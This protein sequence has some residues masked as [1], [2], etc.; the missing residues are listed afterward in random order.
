MKMHLDTF[1]L[2]ASLEILTFKIL[3]Q[4]L[5]TNVIIKRSLSIILTYACL[6]IQ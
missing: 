1:H 2:F 5:E 6:C 4:K 3:V